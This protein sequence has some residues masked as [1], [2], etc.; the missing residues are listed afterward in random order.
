MKLRLS[1]R[2]FLA[3]LVIL[4]VP[5][6]AMMA[7]VHWSF[8]R[9]FDD[10]LHRQE[11]EHL[12]RLTRLL[13]D[14][15]QAHGNWNFIR[16]SPLLWLH[17]IQRGTRDRLRPPRP[18]PPPPPPDHPWLQVPG[19]HGFPP[20]PPPPRN[21]FTMG[22]RLYLQ[23]ADH[24]RI[25]GPPFKPRGDG[26]PGRSFSTLPI[27]VDHQ[28][29]GWLEVERNPIVSDR[30]ARAF[31]DRQSRIN[32]LILLMTLGIA[33][34]S[35]IALSRQ[36]LRP[37][38]RIAAGTRTLAGGHYAVSLPVTGDELGDLARDFN[39]LAATLQ[40]HE[41]A[42]RRWIADIS[43]ELRTPLAILR[44]E[45]EAMQD[46]IRPCTPERIASLHHE[47]LALNG[48]VNDLYELSLSDLGALIYRR[49]PM[50]LT[51]LL[52]Q[53]VA[54]QQARFAGKSI[55]LSSRTQDSCRID[56]DAGR[57]SQLLSNLLENSYRYTEAGGECRL[58][59]ALDGDQARITL[60]DS[61]PGVPNDALPHLFERLYRV[62]ASRGREHG[63]AGLG[64]AIAANI[65]AAHDGRILASHSPLGGLRIEIAIPLA[66]SKPSEP[67]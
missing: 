8:R 31:I 59:L 2:L 56:G 11:L 25:A 51:P 60:D 40:S 14:S 17:L 49:E 35:S 43:H 45:I 34:L 65:V 46:G 18:L 39:H 3:I 5:L 9:G 48:L 27:K 37:L 1:T 6:G 33:I 7:S 32:G 29:V 64:L 24:E 28:I 57:L 44:G 36:I 62:D 16:D 67:T 53:A 15:Y 38:R 63:G 21:P 61:A 22:M 20:P 47:V 10:Y 54:N 12:G 50:D 58:V 4:L 19:G 42:R 52:T 66:R 41:S 26:P 13:A 23:N 30:L 55:R